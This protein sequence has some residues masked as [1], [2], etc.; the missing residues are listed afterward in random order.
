MVT[1]AVC[2]WPSKVKVRSKAVGSNIPLPPDEKVRCATFQVVGFWAFALLTRNVPVWP[3]P[4]WN[5]PDNAVGALPHTPRCHDCHVERHEASLPGRRGRSREFV[6]MGVRPSTPQPATD[7]R[8]RVRLRTVARR[9]CAGCATL[10]PEGISHCPAC[11]TTRGAIPQPASANRGGCPT[12]RGHS[13]PGYGA[14]HRRETTRWK[15]HAHAGLVDCA[16]LCADNPSL[17]PVQ[18]CGLG[19]NG[20]GPLA[21]V[22]TDLAAGSQRVEPPRTAGRGTVMG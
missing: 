11:E 15:P 20:A 2:D 4:Q 12:N 3:F 9:L 7:R 6:L 5:I 18:Q 22:A 21:E 1:C 17:R 8:R 16:S 13:S 14:A 10:I 19:R